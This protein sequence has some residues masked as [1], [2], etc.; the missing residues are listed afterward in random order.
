MFT[1]AMVIDDESINLNDAGVFERQRSRF[2]RTSF[3]YWAFMEFC[4]Q[5]SRSD[6]QVVEAALHRMRRRE[7][8]VQASDADMILGL[9][10]GTT[11]FFNHGG[12]VPAEAV[13][14]ELERRKTGVAS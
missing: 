9:T 12:I 13:L 1:R 6:A 5:G 4:Q 11:L 2:P 7:I 3:S 14:A 10:D 8:P